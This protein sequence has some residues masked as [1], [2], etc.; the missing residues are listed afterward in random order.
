MLPCN[1]CG[2]LKEFNASYV[3]PIDHLVWS[4]IPGSTGKKANECDTKRKCQ[5]NPPRAVAV[6]GDCVPVTA[7]DANEERNTPDEVV[8]IHS[9][10]ATTCYGCNGH[11]Q[12]KPS[13][14]LPSAPYD[15]PYLFGYKPILSISQDPKLS[16]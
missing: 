7:K 13:A 9:T 5:N 15:Q 4:G 2:L 12:N 16:K 3:I 10:S 14:P 11:V 1:S 8:F 6:Y